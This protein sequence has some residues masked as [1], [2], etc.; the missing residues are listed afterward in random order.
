[1]EVDSPVKIETK[2]GTKE[3]LV[4]TNTLASALTGALRFRTDGVTVNGAELTLAPGETISDTIPSQALAGATAER[5][6]EIEF[7]DQYGVPSQ[8]PV[9]RH[10]FPKS[11][12]TH[13]PMSSDG[14]LS[15]WLLE[16]FY[17]FDSIEN[18]RTGAASWSGPEDLMFRIGFRHDEE[19][20]YIAVK[21]TDQS[22]VQTQD[23]PQGLWREDALQIGLASRFTGGGW[24]VSQ[25]LTLALRSTEGNIILHRTPH[26]SGLQGGS[27]RPSTL[28]AHVVREGN[29][30]RYLLA[31]PWAEID[32]QLAPK[33]IP[34]RLGIGVSVHDTDTDN[35][36]PK[37]HKVM[38]GF[39]KGM[40]FF[41]PEHFGVLQLSP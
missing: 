20:L 7:V 27:L 14:S 4:L 35:N 37:A 23:N 24:E 33:S 28:G 11:S 2:S 5:P 1:V 17:T 12:R 6:I 15:D 9:L 25:K 34:A 38:E 16:D 22:H 19:R 39:G 31:I 21:V 41:S 30:T 3:E 18:L 40:E 10:F 32:P 8:G 29:E 26:T 36:D 13:Q